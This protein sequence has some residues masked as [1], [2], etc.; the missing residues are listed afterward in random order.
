MVVTAAAPSQ[1][2]SSARAMAKLTVL[3]GESVPHG[4]SSPERR[5]YNPTPSPARTTTSAGMRYQS[6]DLRRGGPAAAAWWGGMAG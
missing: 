4:T 3:P 5:K 6:G 2:L 1:A